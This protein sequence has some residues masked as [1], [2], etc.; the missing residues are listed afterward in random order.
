MDTALMIARPA[1]LPEVS[2]P[3]APV[4]AAFAG[5]ERVVGALVVEDV[6]KLFNQLLSRAALLLGH[7]TWQDGAELYVL[8]RSCAELVHRKFR[9]LKPAEIAL[10][11][12][13]GASGEYK[14]KADE[15][16]YVQ[17]PAITAWL[18]AYQTTARHE[19]IKALRKADEAELLALPAPVRDYAGEAAALVQQADAGALPPAHALDFGNVLY[20]WLKSIGALRADVWPIEPPD[21]NTI[22][23][24]ETDFLLT[25]P[26]PAD[27]FERRGRAGFLETLLAGQWP[28]GHPLA[29]TVANACKKRVLRE[30]VIQCAAE[31]TDVPTL[32]AGLVSAHQQAA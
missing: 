11:M 16:V 2:A 27:K 3:L 4:L 30:W 7:K 14:A 21:Y 18:Y 10:A 24:E 32:L 20:D 29:K 28:E 17:L 13:R 12:D 15:V 8:A 5:D 26:P 22:R 19:A 1:A 6:T 25:S 31:E 23:V 9:G